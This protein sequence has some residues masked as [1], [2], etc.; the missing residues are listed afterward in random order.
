M[1]GKLAAAQ[2]VYPRKSDARG[3]AEFGATVA[4]REEE[5]GRE[6]AYQMV[7]EGEAD[8][9]AGRLSVHSPLG[10][11]LIEARAGDGVTVDAPAG[12]QRYEVVAVR[13]D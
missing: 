10:S 3:R 9:S 2:V 8:I 1:E 5:T 4:L 6:A 13:Y 11:A 7:G 12:E